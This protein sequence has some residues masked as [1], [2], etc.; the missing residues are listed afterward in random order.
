M[1][2]PIGAVQIAAAGWRARTMF[3]H[4]SSWHSL[5]RGGLAIARCDVL[6]CPLVS[7]GLER[8]LLESALGLDRFWKFGWVVSVRQTQ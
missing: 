7:N 2:P 6:G 4:V 8:G 1:I 3:A 5:T